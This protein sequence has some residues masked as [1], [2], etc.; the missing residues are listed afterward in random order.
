MS[1]TDSTELGA[2]LR[3]HRSRLQP[4]DVGL[5]AYGARRVPGLRREELAELAGV[6]VMYY[7]RLEQGQHVNASAAVIDALATAL[8]LTEDERA[9]LHNLA[10]P[11][12]LKRRRAPKPATVRP[13]TRQLIDAM[14]EVPAVVLGIRSEVL[15]WNTLGHQ[16]F[17]PQHAFDAPED[18][19]TRPNLTRMFFLDP[20]SRAFHTRWDEEAQ[21]K[22]AS[23]RAYAGLHA[24]DRDMAEL[25]GELTMKSGEFA[26]L[27]A[28]HPVL[29]CVSG[30]KYFH[31]PEVGELELDFE[32]VHLH[33]GTGHRIDRYS[34]PRGSATHRALLRLLDSLSQRA[35]AN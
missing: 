12:P 8:R 30:T 23:L 31:H 26:A 11:P 16:L 13:T 14:P 33:D 20:R 27:W 3:L 32:A 19:A 4:Q 22:V 1:T 34:S 6:S 21:R 24:D 15:A 25:V 29:N 17:G 9:H 7:T 5:T 18:P 28:T 10:G 2:F 35:A